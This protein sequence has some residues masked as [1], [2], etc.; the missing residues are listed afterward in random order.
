ME[1]MLQ[2]LSPKS[3]TAEASPKPSRRKWTISLADR[4]QRLCAGRTSDLKAV[5]QSAFQ[6][7]QGSP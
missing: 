1:K 7:A 4:K 6:T 3:E 5:A 2:S